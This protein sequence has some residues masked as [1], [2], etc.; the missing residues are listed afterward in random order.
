MIKQRIVF[1][2][3]GKGL[4]VKCYGAKL[5]FSYLND[6]D[7][8]GAYR[9]HFVIGKDAEG[10]EGLKKAY[11]ELG[12][13]RFPQMKWT[14]AAL[15]DGDLIAQENIEAGKKAEDF[16]HYQGSMVLS[17]KTYA[18]KKTGE[19][20]DI[21]GDCYSGAI[22]AA[23]MLIC[24]YDNTDDKGTR[25]YGLH[26]YLNGVQ[27]QEDGPRLGGERINADALGLDPLEGMAKRPV[28]EYD[29]DIPF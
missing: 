28:K 17:A 18:D 23:V 14:S 11:L 2:T 12:R 9:S 15:K 6:P 1:E 19:A 24:P 7:D 29:S 27:W 5:S 26:A 13:A 3:S 16:A 20:P 22:A 8:K 4:L 10:L 25:S 21:R